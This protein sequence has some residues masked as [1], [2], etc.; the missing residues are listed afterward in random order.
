MQALDGDVTLNGSYSTLLNKKEPDIGFSYDIKDM[1]VQKAFYAFNTIQA[2]MPVGKFLSGKLNSQLSMVGK[3]QG[4]MMP[5]LMSL[6]GKGNLLLL[7]GVLMKFA[8]L[9]KLATVLQIDRL[10]KISLK[11]LKRSQT[12]PAIIAPNTSTRDFRR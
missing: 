5:K 9:E 8:P 10:K 6:T 4:D 1:D 2:L 7:K 3:M 11:E 12:S